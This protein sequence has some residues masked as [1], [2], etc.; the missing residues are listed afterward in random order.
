MT[1][2]VVNLSIVE[3]RML[4]KA[5]AARRCGRSPRRFELEC[6]VAPVCFPNGDKLYDVRDVDAWLDRLK[7]NAGAA[8]DTDDIVRRLG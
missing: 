4:T 7:G 1:S 6:D 2:A 3:K 8:A 5:E